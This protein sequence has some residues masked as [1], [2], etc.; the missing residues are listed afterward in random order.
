MID[1]KLLPL[2]DSVYLIAL[3]TWIGSLAFWLFGVA[4]VLR[5]HLTGPQLERVEREIAQRCCLWGTVASALALGA[6]VYGTLSSPTLRG[7]LAGAAAGLILC[8]TLSMLYV[9]NGLLP[10][11]AKLNAEPAEEPAATAGTRARG[12]QTIESLL[13]LSL[14]IGL[15]LLAA[16]AF[17]DRLRPAGPAQA[18]SA[19]EYRRRSLAFMEHN[20]Q[21]WDDYKRLGPM[22]LGP[23]AATNPPETSPGVPPTTTPQ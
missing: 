1:G 20:Q 13:T 7:P 8:A 22:N 17:R 6:L 21:F 2:F 16:H 11:L 3:A 18:P 10:R 4:P 5:R 9:A 23:E 19:E 12:K 15:G 14:V